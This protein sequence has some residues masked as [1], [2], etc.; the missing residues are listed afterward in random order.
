[1]EELPGET[2]RFSNRGERGRAP[3]CLD[4]STP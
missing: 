3:F 1:V 4:I 2:A